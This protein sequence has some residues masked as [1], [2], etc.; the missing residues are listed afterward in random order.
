MKRS[1]EPKRSRNERITRVGFYQRARYSYAIVVKENIKEDTKEFTYFERGQLKAKWIKK[2]F[3]P[4]FNLMK[5][6]AQNKYW[7]EEEPKN[8][9]TK[10]QHIVL[11]VY[12]Y[13]HGYEAYEIL[14]GMIAIYRL[15]QSIDCLND[16]INESLNVD[17]KLREKVKALLDLIDSYKT[18][19]DLV[20]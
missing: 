6:K 11:H 1:K 17:C 7:L 2:I 10:N 20:M 12:F 13:N 15:N 3:S 5:F 14:M 4:H 8:K 9:T 19:Y 16:W 18:N